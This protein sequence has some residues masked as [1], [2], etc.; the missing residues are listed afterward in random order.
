MM[1]WNHGTFFLPQLLPITKSLSYNTKT[2]FVVYV[3]EILYENIPLTKMLSCVK[4]AKKY[5][6][7]CH[8]HGKYFTCWDLRGM[9]GTRA[10]QNT[11]GALSEFP[12]RSAMHGK[13][14]VS[15]VISVCDD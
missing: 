9:L 1:P 10:D 8:F 5:M 2:R 7:V 13:S 6:H 4:V 11:G 3:V 14:R 12:M 15:S